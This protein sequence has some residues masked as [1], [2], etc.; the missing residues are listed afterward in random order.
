M[1]Q[2]HFRLQFCVTLIFF[3]VFLQ[4]CE[5]KVSPQQPA[6]KAEAIVEKF[7]DSWTRGESPDKFADPAQPVQGIDP[8]WKAGHRLL[9]FLSVEA[10]QS[11]ETPNQVRCRVA[12]STQDPKGK[13]VNKEVVYEVQVGEKYVI[14]RMLR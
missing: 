9:S 14:S 11:Q 7:L 8:D 4:G 10:K 13:K 2:I 3:S 5:K 12:L 1:R 6:D